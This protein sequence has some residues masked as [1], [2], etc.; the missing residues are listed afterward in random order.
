MVPGEVETKTL[1]DGQKVYRLKSAAEW[2]KA[3]AEM[4]QW[5][6]NELHLIKSPTAGVVV[7]KR[8]KNE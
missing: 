2:Q 8:K 1:K 6:E 7:V 4:K 5:F 3:F